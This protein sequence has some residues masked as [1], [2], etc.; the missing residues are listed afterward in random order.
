MILRLKQQIAALP[1]GGI[2]IKKVRGKE[3]Y[4]HRFTQNHKRNEVYLGFGEAGPLRA[5][6][7][8]RKTLEVELKKLKNQ[9]SKPKKACNESDNHKFNSLRIGAQLKAYAVQVKQYKNAS[10][11]SSLPIMCSENTKTRYSYCTDSGEREKQ[12]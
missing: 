4:Y 2:A 12:Q 1:Q 9:L 6:I 10:A 8:K 5:K 11:A 7:E 3:Y